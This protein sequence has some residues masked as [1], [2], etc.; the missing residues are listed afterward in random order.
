GLDDVLRA[1]TPPAGAAPS[2]GALLVAA[3]RLPAAIADALDR[4]LV[5]MLDEFQE[6]TRLRA[7]P[8]TENLL[9]ALRAALDRPGRVAFVVAGSRVSALRHLLSDGENP[10][11]TRFEQ[12]ELRPFPPEATHE[13]ASRLWD[14]EGIAAEPDAAVRLHRLTGGW[15]FYVHAVAARA[16][17]LARTG[18]GRVTDD[19]IDLAF[20]HEL[21]GR[22][23][24]LGQYCRYLLDAALRTD[25][26]GLRNTLEAVLRHKLLVLYEQEALA[27][28]LDLAYVVR[29]LLSEGRLRYGTVEKRSGAAGQ[30]GEA[31]TGRLIEKPGPTA[32]FTSTTRA[33]VEPELETRTVEVQTTD[34]AE[35]SRAVIRGTA[36]RY[37]GA[38]PA[39]PDLARGTPSSAGYA[40]PA[41]AGW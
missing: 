31:F 34:T 40:S 18:G 1:L 4:P 21:L 22:A 15:P 38:A 27:D 25:T 10:L 35:H 19:T 28:D 32:L 41:N 26:S 6:I 39:A 17:Q 29:S 7:F 30:G 24:A 13:L 14:E 36:A 5:V 9:G 11:F 12:L 8:G 20:R 2:Y 33:G 23:A 16:R 3:M 37:T